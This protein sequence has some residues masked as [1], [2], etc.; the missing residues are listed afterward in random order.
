[1]PAS[2]PPAESGHSGGPP[3]RIP[4]R[5]RWEDV[6]LAGVMRYSAYT[7]LFDAAEAELLRAAGMPIGEV[8][9]QLGVWMPRKL[10]NVEYFAPARFDDALEIRAWVAG[11]GS[12]SLTLAGEVWSGD[13]AV[14]HAA[15]T[16][17]LVCVDRDGFTKRPWPE[18]LVAAISPFRLDNAAASHVA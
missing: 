11:V 15:I 8:A 7:R 3:F 9:E 10:L 6:D 17:V 12:T 1:M 2:S 18:K 14:R 16:V 5:V 4:E 13:G